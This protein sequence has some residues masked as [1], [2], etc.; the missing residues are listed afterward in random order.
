MQNPATHSTHTEQMLQTQNF[1]FLI[2]V[3]PTHR[4]LRN[5]DHISAFEKDV[6]LQVFPVRDFFV[7]ERKLDGPSGLLPN[8]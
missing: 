3:D 8:N 7:I 5:N 2:L 1:T 6:L 4:V